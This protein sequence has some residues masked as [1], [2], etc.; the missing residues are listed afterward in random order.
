[1]TRQRAAV[2]LMTN[3][4][5]GR[6]MYRSLFADRIQPVFGFGLP[7]LR[8]DSVPGAAGDL[9]RFAGVYAW[10]DRQL[11]VAPT[12]TG[13]VIRSERRETAALPLDDRSFLIDPTDPE[14]PC[15]TFGAFDASG[16]PM[17]LYEMLWGLPRRIT[18]PA[19]PTAGHLATGRTRR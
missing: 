9:S 17:V 12:P 10:A 6:A 2:E 7:S 5:T 11:D 8:L 16:R 4:S 19:R 13:L 14:N 1:M 3:C 18:R 15:V